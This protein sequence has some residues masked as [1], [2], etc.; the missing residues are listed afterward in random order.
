MFLAGNAAM[1]LM[2]SVL[3]R[4]RWK[5]LLVCRDGLRTC[6]AVADSCFDGLFLLEN[7]K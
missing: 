4:E 2:S 1:F 7:V 6:R 5:N 3:Y